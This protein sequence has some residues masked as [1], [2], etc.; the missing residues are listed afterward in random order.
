MNAISF[1]IIMSHNPLEGVK[2]VFHCRNKIACWWFSEIKKESP[3]PVYAAKWEC[4]GF[5]WQALDRSLRFPGLSFS[6]LYNVGT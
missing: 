5:L 6:H 2:L 4:F 1:M 3:K